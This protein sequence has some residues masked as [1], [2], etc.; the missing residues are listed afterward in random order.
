[1]KG[2]NSVASADDGLESDQAM[3]GKCC[4]ILSMEAVKAALGDVYDATVG[5]LLRRELVKQ[6]RAVE[7]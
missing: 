5:Q 7:M 3:R 1:M 6:A 2:I 4:Q